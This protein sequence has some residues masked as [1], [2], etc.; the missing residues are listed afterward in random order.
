LSG[1][2]HRLNVFSPV[3]REFIHILSTGAAIGGG[4]GK[5]PNLYFFAPN[6]YTRGTYE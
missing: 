4:I 5:D 3:L 1:L 2:F 6:L